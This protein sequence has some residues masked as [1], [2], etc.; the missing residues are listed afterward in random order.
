MRALEALPGHP[1]NG[2]PS[3]HLK[4]ELGQE[5]PPAAEAGG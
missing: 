4:P 3:P 5:P 2:H 1:S